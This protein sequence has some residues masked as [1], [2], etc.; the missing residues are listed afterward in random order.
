MEDH[1]LTDLAF[2]TNRTSHTW[3]RQGRLAQS[4]RIDYILTSIP[5]QGLDL[6]TTRTNTQLTTFDHVFLEATFGQKITPREMS[7]KDYILGSE[8]YII[9]SME[10]VAKTIREC[11]APEPRNMEQEEANEP[12]ENIQNTG[13]RKR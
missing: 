4:S 9:T 11:A 6:Q 8:E 13:N 3:Y 7:M 5:T 1:N 12:Q 10:L 2:Q